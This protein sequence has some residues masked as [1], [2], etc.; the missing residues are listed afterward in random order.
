[1]SVFGPAAPSV[2]GVPTTASEPFSFQLVLLPKC[3]PRAFVFAV[4]SNQT[5][6]A[7]LHTVGNLGSRSDVLSQRSLASSTPL[8][9]PSVRFV[10]SREVVLSLRV[11]ISLGVGVGHL[12]TFSQIYNMINTS[13]RITVMK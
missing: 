13:S 1:M 7:V 2:L 6:P 3:N 8:H 10:S 11:S 4:P 12:K 9:L 5:V